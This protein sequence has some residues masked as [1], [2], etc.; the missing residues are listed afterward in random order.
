MG[1]RSTAAE[2]KEKAKKEGS[3]TS[4]ESSEGEATDSSSSRSQ[5]ALKR[6]K[7]QK[8]TKEE[9]ETKDNKEAKRAKKAKKSKKDQKAAHHGL[10]HPG[11]LG[12]M[13]TA[14][15]W[16]PQFKPLPTLAHWVQKLLPLLAMRLVQLTGG[17]AGWRSLP[18]TGPAITAGAL[19]GTTSGQ[20]SF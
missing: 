5:P 6:A 19:E 14:G 15:P 18:S 4:H 17:P 7:E 13:N 11:Q 2:P 16:A 12:M 10:P 3:S 9:K 20:C 8:G 1:L